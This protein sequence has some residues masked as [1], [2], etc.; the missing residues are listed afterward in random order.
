MFL[1]EALVNAITH[2]NRG[3]CG[4]DVRLTMTEDG[5]YCLIRVYDRGCGFCPD[6]IT[7]PD[8]DKTDGRGICLIRHCM[9]EVVYDG[10]EHCLEMKMRRKAMC[11]GG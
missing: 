2:G 7:V 9:D 3:D 5:E 1:E 4:L 6:D 8:P 10:V 11:H